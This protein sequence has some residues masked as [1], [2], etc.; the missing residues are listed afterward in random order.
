MHT[1][2]GKT[3]E[4]GN[5]G[6]FFQRQQIFVLPPPGSMRS[7]P[8]ARKRTML[9]STLFTIKVHSRGEAACPP[10]P[11]ASPSTVPATT[12]SGSSRPFMTITLEAG[13]CVGVSVRRCCRL[14][15]KK[16]K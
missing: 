3:H 6:V 10:R 4:G 13:G 2:S 7:T 1:R 16:K 15:C 11:P 8:P 9:P 5:A 14:R 12:P